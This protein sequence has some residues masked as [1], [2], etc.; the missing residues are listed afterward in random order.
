MWQFKSKYAND[1][2]ENLKYWKE[3]RR[4]A[5]FSKW[6]VLYIL[7]TFIDVFFYMTAMRLGKTETKWK[8]NLSVHF[9]KCHFYFQFCKCKHIRLVLK[10]INNK[11]ILNKNICLALYSVFCIHLIYNILCRTT[12]KR[13]AYDRRL[14]FLGWRTLHEKYFVGGVIIFLSMTKSF[15]FS[16]IYLSNIFCVKNYRHLVHLNNGQ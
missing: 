14:L 7:S 13:T 1:L 12:V 6:C 9:F 8:K 10:C 2:N 16:D 15:K 4:F 5:W 3:K 11:R